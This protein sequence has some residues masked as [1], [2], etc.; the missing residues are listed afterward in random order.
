M[1]KISWLLGVCAGS[2]FTVC[3]QNLAPITTN[4]SVVVT[5]QTASDTNAPAADLAQ[6][7]RVRAAIVRLAALQANDDAASL[8]AILAE[9]KN[10]NADIRAAAV[11]AVVQFNDRSAIPALQQMAD[12]TSDSAEKMEILKAIDYMKLPSLAEFSAQQHAL[13]ALQSATNA[14]AVTT[15]NPSARPGK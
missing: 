15:T 1:K 9:L 5:N 11:Q 7:K 6:Q 13:A 14:P 2:A 4:A 8:A 10:P 3:G 12:A